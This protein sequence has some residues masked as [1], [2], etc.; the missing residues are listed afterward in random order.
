MA[1]V[2]IPSGDRLQLR[3]QVGTNPQNGNPFTAA[4][5]GP[6]LNPEQQ[7]SISTISLPSWANWGGCTGEHF[8]D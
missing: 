2:A 3:V 6:G 8:Q 7:T 4:D 5:P 1:V